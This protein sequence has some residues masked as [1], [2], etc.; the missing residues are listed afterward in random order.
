MISS[1]DLSKLKL[2]LK[3]FHH[4][5]RIRITVFDDSFH[6]LAAYPELPAPFCQII[7]SDPE[8]AACCHRCDKRACETAAKRRTLYTYRCHAGLTESI[9]PIIIGNIPIGYLLFG[10]V[11]SYPSYEEGWR[12]IQDLCRGYRI[13]FDALNAACRKQ[14]A[15]T[16]DYISSASQIGRAHV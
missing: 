5:T 10:Q 13:N 9:T 2:L 4:M 12:Q 6:E 11:F 15:V 3:D 7:R 14:P 8:A 16:A 1:F